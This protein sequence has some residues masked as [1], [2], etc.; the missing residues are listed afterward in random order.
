MEAGDRMNDFLTV[1]LLLTGITAAWL[2]IRRLEKRLAAQTETSDKLAAALLLERRCHA[3]AADEARQYRA[4]FED[5]K[6]QR[7]RALQEARK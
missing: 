7:D 3:E 2:T 4:A 1:T 6:H 5:M